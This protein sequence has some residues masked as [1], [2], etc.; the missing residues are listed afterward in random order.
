MQKRVITAIVVFVISIFI[1]L[2]S[3][4]A[5]N[6]LTFSENSNGN[7][8]ATLHFEEGFVGGFDI[9]LKYSGNVKYKQINL[10]SNVAKS[11]TKE[12]KHDGNN[13]TIRIIVSTGGVGTGHN[14]LN[15]NKELVLGNIIFESDAKSNTTYSFECSKL[16]IVANDWYSKNLTPELGTHSFTYKINSPSTD[17]DKQD[18]NK[19]DDDKKDT[20]DKKDNNKDNNKD[21]QSSSGNNVSNNGSQSSGSSSNSSNGSNNSGSSNNSSSN[22]SSSNNGTDSNG[23]GVSGNDD[24]YD[25]YSDYSEDGDDDE[26]SKDGN[27]EETTNEEDGL[28]KVVEII[29]GVALVG[30]AGTICFLAIKPKKVKEIK[31]DKE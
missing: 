26:E 21:N 5:A 25:D 13:H 16:T 31:T 18:D 24:N 6:K 29:I 1:S 2:T 23:S 11:S 20:D 27:E 30:L 17:N 9:T 14:L 10:D 12:I 7:I 19:Q 3:V 22:G 15:A 4:S 28:S 8:K